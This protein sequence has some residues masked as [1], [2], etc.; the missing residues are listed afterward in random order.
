M[1]VDL[2]ILTTI[3]P[4]ATT[5]GYHGFIGGEG[6]EA[7]DSAIGTLQP[8]TVTTASYIVIEVR[9]T[10]MKAVQFATTDYFLTKLSG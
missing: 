10:Y 3:I 8:L 7:I 4:V 5:G 9:W 2:T 6:I 1:H